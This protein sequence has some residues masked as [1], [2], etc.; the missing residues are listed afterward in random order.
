MDVREQRV[1]FVV[2]ASR[3]EQPFGAVCQEYGIS[4]ATGYMWLARFAEGGVAGIAERSRRPHTSPTL[5]AAAVEEQVVA[6]RQRFPDWGARKLSV[7]LGQQGVVVPR[8]TLHRILLRHGLVRDGDRHAPAPGRFERA[9]PNA[10]WQMDFKGPL[11]PGERLG[12]LSVLDDHS[13]YVICLHQ[14]AGTRTELVREQREGAFAACGVPEAML[15]D[16]GVPWWNALAAQGRTRLGL[17]LMKQGVELH[18]SRVRHPQTQGKVERFHGE[19]QRAVRRRQVQPDQAWL[20]QYRREHNEERPHEALG[21]ATPASRWCRSPRRYEPSPASWEYPPAARVR[22]L[23]SD[24]KL[25]L[26]GRRWAISRSLGGERVQL[27]T[28]EHRIEVYYC[29]TLIRELDLASQQSTIVDCWLA[30][31]FPNPEL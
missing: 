16:H 12:P 8:S 29:R 1:S 7:R 6:L 20:D 3:G 4:R 23:D 24:G 22:K 19:L 11:W 31:E 27:V 26:Q 18:W 30:D 15:M 25:E 17:W 5:T 14:L 9:A 2:T 28:M 10:L 21:M 13:R